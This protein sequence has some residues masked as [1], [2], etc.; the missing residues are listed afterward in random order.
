MHQGTARLAKIVHSPGFDHCLERASIDLV[1]IDPAA[2]FGQAAVSAICV[3]LCD[4]RFDRCSADPL[5]RAK[6][7]ENRAIAG[8]A[9]VIGRPVDARCLQFEAELTAVVLERHEAIGIVQICAHYCGHERSWIMR[10]QVCGLVR[11][12]RVC[13]RMRLVETIPC[14]LLHQIE[15]AC[16]SRLGHAAFGRARHEDLALLRH[17]LGFLLAHRTTQEIG[18]AE[19]I[20]RE[21]LRDLHNLF[22]VQNNAVGFFEYRLEI[23]VQVVD[24]RLVGRMLARDEIVDHARLQ[25]TRTEQGHQR[26]KIAELVGPQSLDEVTHAARLELEHGRSLSALQQPECLG[27][28]HRHATDVEQCV[29]VGRV[30]DAFRPIDDRE[31]LQSEEVELD[32]ADR[33]DIVLVE[34]RDQAAAAVFAVE[35]RKI[36]E[37]IGRN[38]DAAGMLACVPDQ[39]LQRLRQIDDGG[40]LFV[41]AVHARQLFRLLQ[42][43]VEGHPDFEGHQLGDAIDK[44]IRLPENAAGIADHRPRRHGAERNDLRDAIAAIACGHVI[45]DPVAAL[46]AEVD[47]EVRHRNTFRVQETLEEEIVFERIQISDTQNPGHQRSC[48]RSPARTHGDIVI[49]RPANEIGDNQEV[50]RKTHAADHPQLGIQP[51][52][53][54]GLERVAFF[55]RGLARCEYLLER[56]VQPP[57]RL[58]LEVLLFRLTLRHREGGQYACAELQVEVAAP[59][60]FERVFERFRHIGEQLDHLGG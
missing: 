15:D 20:T 6:A 31:R 53:V 7:I 37:M 50:T 30:D 29:R 39:A 13:S 26:D 28:I 60:N 58:G 5:Y 48:A 14:E 25:G 40:D 33:L 4:Q 2:E 35:R 18:A 56:L 22:L 3:A 19:G 47:V 55:L 44:A 8:H 51:R 17:L 41:V 57:P 43:L 11:Q 16:R 32:Q 49:A 46:H 54:R 45:D 24:F 42:C 10:F 21:H 23:R 36:G 38:H 27:V 52:E 1:M 9:E 12:H 34:L 59:G